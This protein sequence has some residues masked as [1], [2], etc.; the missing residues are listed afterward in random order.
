[1]PRQKQS[2][3]GKNIAYMILYHIFNALSPL[4]VTP[5]LSRVLGSTEIGK[6]SYAHSLA[7]YFVLVAN[8]GIT[9]H[10]SRRIAEAK[11]NKELYD[12][13]FSDLFWLHTFNALIVT[14]IYVIAVLVGMNKD[15]AA[16]S[17]IMIFYV[18]SSVFDVKWLFYGLE[19]F[20][21]TVLRSIII[22]I[23]YIILIFAFVK[24]R[25][26][27]KIYTFIMSFVAYFIAEA[28]LFVMLPKYGKIHKP[29]FSSIKK[30]ILPLFLLFI[31]SVANVLLRHFD[32]LML[33]W[34]SSYD[35]LGMYE[36]TDKIFLVLVT[37]ITAVGDVIMPR[38]SNLLASGATSKSDKLLN[39]ALRISIL[40]SCAFTFGIM[41]ISKEFVPLFLGDDF[42][43]CIQLL[44]W[45]APTIIMLTFSA[46]I[47]KQYLIPNYLER[48]FLTATIFSLFINII[49]NAV[50]IPKYGALG[51][52]FGTIIAEMSVVVIQFIMI[53]KIFNYMPFIL[54]L[55]KYCMIGI[56]M[57]T[58]I[59]LTSNINVGYFVKLLVEIVVGAFIYITVS[60][61]VMKFTHDELFDVIKKLSQKIKLEE[62]RND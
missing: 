30:E 3:L 1:M 27:I 58:G 54:D 39:N 16:L 44:I 29:N 21:I 6:Y 48:V 61:C 19:N 12:K 42:L 20:K 55:I 11:D 47:R 32:K 43:G 7:Y 50:F 60:Y 8:L 24:T 28:S 2:N 33:G 14:I 10:G 37:L 17:F 52:V 53:H 35:Q 31:P 23:A 38:I 57:F 4:I 49:A 56:V 18:I 45:I 25:N 46:L 5:Y 34:M 13:R 15:N 40:V 51:A 62:K 41:A 36:N 59:R 9:I 26:D 22:K